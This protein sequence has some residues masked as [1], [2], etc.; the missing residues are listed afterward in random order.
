MDN[1]TAE[2]GQARRT[3]REAMIAGARYLN[4][5][6]IES[7]RLDAE[8]LLRHVLRIKQAE[9]YLRVEDAIESDT[10]FR[11]WELLQRRARREPLAYITGRKEFWSLDFMVTPDVLIPRPETELLVQAALERAKSMLKPALKI[12]DIGTGS[13]AIAVCMAKELP[14]AQITAVDISGAALRVA[15]VNAEQH[16]VA[17]RIRFMQGDMFA[18]VAEESKSFD[19]I[20]S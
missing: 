7:A 14:Q 13:G 3:L 11:A 4:A 19:L 8:V 5:A 10:E 15:C 6:G 1:R 17:D 2:V 20:L 12:I 18:A 16:R 9:F